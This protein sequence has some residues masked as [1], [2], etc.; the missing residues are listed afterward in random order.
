ML[1]QDAQSGVGE[2]K[3]GPFL[4]AARAHK[5]GVINAKDD[6]MGQK[7]RSYMAVACDVI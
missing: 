6:P 7:T 3:A 1:P 2:G 5:A 4:N